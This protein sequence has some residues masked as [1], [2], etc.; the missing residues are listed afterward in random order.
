MRS[1]VVIGQTATASPD[2][3]LDDLPSSSGRL[4]V[5][6]RCVRAALLFSHGLRSDV[7]VYLLLRGGPMAPRVLRI[8]SNTARFVR[9]DERSLAL[10]VQKTLASAPPELESSFV[11]LRPGVALARGD[12]ECVLED[13]EGAALYV[14]QEQAPELRAMTAAP[15][16]VAGSAAFF[17]GDHLGFADSDLARLEAAGATA[18]SIG[19]VSL[20][21]DDVI[22]VLSNELARGVG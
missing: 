19:P 9:P 15:G 13:L 4:D 21:T 12:L 11:E 16:A 2:F 17:L 10:L 7:R 14:L 1:F 5:L 8:D 20:H 22:A 18:I 6:L 3:R